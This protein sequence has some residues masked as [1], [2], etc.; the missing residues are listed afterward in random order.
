[1]EVVFWLCIGGV[2]ATYVVYPL[3]IVALGAM[4]SG[5][6]RDTDHTPKVTMVISAYN[7]EAVIQAKLENTLAIDYPA[8]KLEIFVIS[9][10]ST[11]ATDDI[12]RG[13]ANRGVRLQRQEPRG[14]K[15][16]GL[17]R[18]IPMAS[19]EIL[20][21]SDAN[22]IYNPAA[23]R[24]LVRPFSDHRVGYVVGHQRN[25]EDDDSPVSVSER[26]YWW[27][28]VHL[29]RGESRIGSVVGG[30]GAIF[31]IRTHLFSPLEDDDLSDFVLPLRIVVDGYRGVFQESAHCSEH[32]AGSFSGEF[33]RKSRI[34]NRALTAVMRVPAALN[35]ARVG[36]FALQLFFHK[37]LR[38]F[39]PYL[40]LSALAANV[41]LVMAGTSIVY[42]YLLAVQSTVYVLAAFGGSR[43]LRQIPA[44]YV[45]YYFCL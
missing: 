37:V 45:L 15:S 34:V 25:V 12:V 35:P 9:D 38:W 17:T 27:L 26:L 2:F 44:I 7:E 42:V 18:F 10:D 16:R 11:D 22:S 40:L 33:R 1:M 4:S 5:S 39:V 14:G 32:V 21:F 23:M 24:E 19:G 31:A 28:E 6:A 3:I 13:F 43:T 30:D 20:V 41:M 29:K 8:E 36:W